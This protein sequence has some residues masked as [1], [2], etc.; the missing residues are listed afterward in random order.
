MFCAR[1]T[2][3]LK[4]IQAVG[5]Y[6]LWY[7]PHFSHFPFMFFHYLRR[8]VPLPPSISWCLASCLLLWLILQTFLF[9]FESSRLLSVFPCWVVTDQSFDR[10]YIPWWDSPGVSS[11]LEF[12]RI[13]IFATYAPPAD[14]RT[15]GLWCYWLFCRGC[16]EP[17]VRSRWIVISISWLVPKGSTSQQNLYICNPALKEHGPHQWFDGR[18]LWILLN[19]NKHT[20]QC[21]TFSEFSIDS[22]LIVARLTFSDGA[23]IPST[24]VGDF[25][26]LQLV[27]HEDCVF[28]TIHSHYSS[29]SSAM[30]KYF[31]PW[32]GRTPE[33]VDF[34]L[35][36]MALA[37]FSS[38]SF[39]RPMVLAG[40]F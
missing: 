21:D 9:F 4:V 23:A 35:G 2:T 16:K 34:P 10:H 18:T 28:L 31:S 25:T 26:S 38:M 11:A 13:Q 30:I 39:D 19:A 6:L 32:L 5:F 29:L 14:L 12:W 33:Y 40:L 20:L 3:L 22:V 8:L 15:L 27:D 37:V 36:T 7:I 1:N 17:V 24:T